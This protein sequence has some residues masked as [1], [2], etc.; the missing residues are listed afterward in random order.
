VKK[1]FFQ[2]LAPAAAPASALFGS[3]R[4]AEEVLK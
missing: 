2:N 1:R 3:T 4:I